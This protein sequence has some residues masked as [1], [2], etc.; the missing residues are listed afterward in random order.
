[1][2]LAVWTWIGGSNHRNQH[3]TEGGSEAY[4]GSRDGA[5]SWLDSNSTV[6]MFG[7][8]GYGIKKLSSAKLPTL[9]EFWSFDIKRRRWVFHPF[10]NKTS[11]SE[12]PPPCF[13]CVSC[14]FKNKAVLF[15]PSSTFIFDMERKSWTAALHN[16]AVSPQP[17]SHAAHWCDTEEG[18]MWM[19][20]GAANDEKLDD[21]WKFSFKELQWKE[22][23]PKN[24][25]SAI[26][27]KCAKTTTWMHPSGL[28]YMF[29]GSCPGLPT[30]HFWS[31]SPETLQWTKL[32]GMAGST[33]CAGKYGKMGIASKKN[34]PGCREGAASW[35]DK[36]G[37]LWMF[38]GSGFDNFSTTAFATPGL[39][40][41]LWMYNASSQ[42]WTWV[43]GLSRGE[44]VPSFSEKGKADKHNIPGPRESTVSFPYD[45]QLWMFGGAGHDVK[46]FDGIL[47]DLWMYG[48]VKTQNMMA[49][50]A[51]QGTDNVPGD[52]NTTVAPTLQ[53]TE[54]P[55]D[56][57]SIPFGFRVLIALLVLVLGL[58]VSISTCYSKECR[59]FRLKRH[60]R[61]VV[62]YKPVKVEM[63]QVPQ[64]EV[65]PPLNEQPSRNL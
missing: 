34:Y 19:F 18:V 37:N 32:G 62:K 60:L 3:T 16:N 10:D 45:N 40:S 58:V 1:M 31:Y 6:W 22:I 35:V 7:G 24:N 27:A 53:G 11:N 48:Q 56:T 54:V 33:K 52:T 44:G 21:F 65:N 39:L 4:P 26:P 23:K 12:K 63:M 25:K 55:G 15:G 41:D 9:D 8:R 13:G 46:G 47:N 20:G 59:I 51:L 17:R 57:I 5:A 14:S 64:P 36:H 61:P 30:S 42:Q 2:F 29:G 43:G 50:P 38:G 49:A 28:L